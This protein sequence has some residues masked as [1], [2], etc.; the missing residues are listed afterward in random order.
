MKKKVVKKAAK[1]I[2]Y[3]LLEKTFKG[4]ASQKEFQFAQVKREDK[5]AIYKKSDSDCIYY[6]VIVVQR[7]DGRTMP[8]GVFI[9]PSEFY[10][11]DSM[12]GL[13]GWTYTLLDKAEEKFKQLISKS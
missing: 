1:P 5:I 8:G 3:K 7:H 13:Y 10:P 9:E 12:W 11:S 4:R 2:K 6:E